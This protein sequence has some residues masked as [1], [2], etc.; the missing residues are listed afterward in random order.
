MVMPLWKVITKYFQ[1]RRGTPEWKQFEYF[2]ESWKER[3]QQMRKH[4]PIYAKT[5]MDL[6]C[7]KMWLRSMLNIHVKYIGVDYV[8]RSKHT[9]VCDFNKKEFPEKFVD[10]MFVSGCLEYI[11]NPDWFVEKIAKH[12]STCILSYCTLES[13]PNLE[14]R[15]QYHWKNNLTKEDLISLFSKYSMKNITFEHTDKNHN[16]FVF[17]ASNEKT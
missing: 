1:R 11:N 3:I 5:V 12:S 16:I 15:L 4:I 6:G 2:D 17:I 10:V 9:I 8:K 14:E 7:G 13:F